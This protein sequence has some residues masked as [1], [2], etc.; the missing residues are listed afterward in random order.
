MDQPQDWPRLQASADYLGVRRSVRVAAVVSVFFGAVAV[1]LGLLPPS[2]PVLLL[3]G[4]PLAASGLMSVFAPHPVLL[5]IEA[6]CLVTIG[7]TLFFVTTAQAAVA[8]SGRDIAHF[9]LLGLFQVGWGASAFARLP[10]FGRAH[11]AR[12]GVADLERAAESLEDLRRA[13]AGSDERVIEFTTHDLQTHRHKLKLRPQG[14]LCLLDDGR[15]VAIVT[16]RDVSF[17]PVE[18]NGQDDPLRVTA[19]VGARYFD[20]KISRESLRRVEQWRRGMVR[21]LRAAA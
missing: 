6:T 4:L 2:V 5:A 20:A 16:R 13:T 7:A 15:Q 21:S 3:F 12:G 8:E 14:A 10:H 9:A 17:Q 1:A 18:R 11:A 19:R